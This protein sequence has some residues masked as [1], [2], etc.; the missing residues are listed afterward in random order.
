M[1][2]KLSEGVNFGDDLARGVV[3]LGL[4]FA[5][6]TDPELQQRSRHLATL[7]PGSS[8]EAT[9]NEYLENG[10]LRIVNQTIGRAVRHEKDYAS[11]ILIDQRYSDPKI[12]SKLSSWFRNS[13]LPPLSSFESS[14]E[15]LEKFS[16]KWSS[17][18]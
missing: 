12:R 13:L 10:C 16:E 17:M 5:N 11:I 8:V 1:G 14:I 15:A 7:R 18:D 2:G 6:P 3:I 9:K 4:P